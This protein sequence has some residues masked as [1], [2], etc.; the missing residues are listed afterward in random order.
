VRAETT[1]ANTAMMR[2]MR[3]FGA[4]VRFQ[5]EGGSYVHARVPVAEALKGGPGGATRPG[6][7]VARLMG[8]G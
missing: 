7:R 1:L 8:Q 2:I 4:S 3:G 6:G 5:G